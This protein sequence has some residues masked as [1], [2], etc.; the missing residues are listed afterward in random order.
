MVKKNSR[1]YTWKETLTLPHKYL[2]KTYKTLSLCFKNL[3]NYFTHEKTIKICPYF[4]AKPFA[5]GV[6]GAIYEFR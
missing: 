1:C 5:C 3:Q 2:I 4:H 6:F